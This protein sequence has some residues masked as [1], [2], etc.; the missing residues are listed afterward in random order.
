MLTRRVTICMRVADVC[1]V[2]ALN[3]G[4]CNRWLTRAAH[5]SS[6]MGRCAL[7]HAHWQGARWGCTR[8]MGRHDGTCIMHAESS[9]QNR[10]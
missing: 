9:M 4:S 1:D 10:A 3:V 7:G 5:T 8:N 6:C 2:H